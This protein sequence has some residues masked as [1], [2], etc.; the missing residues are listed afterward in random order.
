[1]QVPLQLLL[2]KSKLEKGH[3]YIKKLLRVT[4]PRYMGSPLDSKQ[5]V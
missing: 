5:L 1:M 4:C 3:N 2:E